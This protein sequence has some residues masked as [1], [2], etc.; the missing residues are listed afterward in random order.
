YQQPL[1]IASSPAD[2]ATATPKST[3]LHSGKHLTLSPGED[4]SI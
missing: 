2:I 1:L 3:H 4:V